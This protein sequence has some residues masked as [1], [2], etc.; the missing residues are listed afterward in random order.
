MV[1]IPKLI[2]IKNLFQNVEEMD[3]IEMTYNGKD[4]QKHFDDL[5]QQMFY[6]FPYE[7]KLK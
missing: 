1:K 7:K 6:I 2:Q 3:N 5:L 4:I